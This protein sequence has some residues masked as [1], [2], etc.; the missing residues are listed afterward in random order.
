MIKTMQDIRTKKVKVSVNYIY[1]KKEEDIAVNYILPIVLDITTRK[2]KN[3]KDVVKAMYNLYDAS[4][5][6]T[7]D[8]IDNLSIISYNLEMINPRFLNES[9]SLFEEALEMLKDLIYTP[10]ISNEKFMLKKVQELET[11]RIDFSDNEV[12]AE[13]RINKM[14]N[15]GNIRGMQSTDKIEELGD[16]KLEELLEY[17][18]RV[19]RDGQTIVQLIG[20]VDP[21][22]QDLVKEK[23]K[24]TDNVYKLGIKQR[25]KQKPQIVHDK[26]KSKQSVAKIGLEFEDSDSSKNEV[27]KICNFILG[28]LITSRM[29]RIIRE[30]YNLA[31]TVTSSIDVALG[32]Q[33]VAT[34]VSESKD[35]EKAL[36]I[37]NTILE[38]EVT[39]KEFYI[40]KTKYLSIIKE[41]LDAPESMAYYQIY[42]TLR[43]QEITMEERLAID[44]KI[45]L[46]DVKK[47]YNKL[48]ITSMYIYGG[49]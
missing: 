12:L 27:Y 37:F 33:I 38:K 2:Y 39:Y 9:E 49:K 19:I 13:Y 16:L 41:L 1:P 18:G 5:Y 20:N 3:S 22:M 23:I 32:N 11:M 15:K 14:M 30:K 8:E 40:A 44:T 26:F 25:K 4:I 28:A 42:D 10:Y 21:Y 43:N 24:L 7:R 17:Q 48:K 34:I 31:Y 6:I 47:E 35:R 29:F 36:R 45:T 46:Q